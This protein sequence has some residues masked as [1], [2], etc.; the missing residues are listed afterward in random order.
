MSSILHPKNDWLQVVLNIATMKLCCLHVAQLCE[1]SYYIASKKSFVASVEVLLSPALY[2]A[3][4]E[5]MSLQ[6]ELYCYYTVGIVHMGQKQREP[7][8]RVIV[9]SLLSATTSYVRTPLQPAYRPWQRSRDPTM[10]SPNAMTC[11]CHR[12][13]QQQTSSCTLDH[14]PS[15][16]VSHINSLSDP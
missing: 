11:H 8:R 1:R 7:T 16:P 13:R 5:Y 12:R 6:E 14:D 3:T 15:T 4:L 10:L 9:M 2:V